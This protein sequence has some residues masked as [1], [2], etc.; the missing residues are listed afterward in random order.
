M[1][2]RILLADDCPAIQ[3]SI[4][5]LL[6][7]ASFEIVAV[8][9]DGDEAVRLA[10]HWHPDVV[11]LDQSMPHRTGIAAA[12]AIHAQLPEMRLILLT[13]SPTEHEVAMA[14]GAGIRACVLKK[15]A[16]DDLV[17]AIH[18]VARGEAFVSAGIARL[19]VEPY[20][21]KAQAGS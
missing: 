13:A 10:L 16:A 12:R 20:L 5:A 11:I 9:R 21:P 4:A 1:P 3:A 19:M 2:I 17:R 18:E 14:L 8:A 7:N 15:D 6:D